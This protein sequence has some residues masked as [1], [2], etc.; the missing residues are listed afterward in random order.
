MQATA[1]PGKLC[2]ILLFMAVRDRIKQ[3]NSIGKSKKII[4]C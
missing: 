2:M 1:P 4:G 3:E